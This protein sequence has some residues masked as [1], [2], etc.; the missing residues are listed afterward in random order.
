MTHARHATLPASLCGIVHDLGS[1]Q[2]RMKYRKGLFMS[3]W[4]MRDM[5]CMTLITFADTDDVYLKQLDH[6]LILLDSSTGT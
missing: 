4:H 6:R 1:S 5:Q 2:S 3:H